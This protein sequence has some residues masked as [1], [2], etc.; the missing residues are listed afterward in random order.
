L[1]IGLGLLALLVLGV[2]ASG[3]VADPS[4]PFG[5]AEPEMVTAAVANSKSGG[6]AG[7]FEGGIAAG[8]G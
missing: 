4:D 3:A 5:G 1:K 6:Q 8:A 2:L 7:W